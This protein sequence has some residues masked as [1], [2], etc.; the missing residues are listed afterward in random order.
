MS[1]W[2]QSEYTKPP[3]CLSVLLYVVTF[4]NGYIV[5]K[6][7]VSGFYADESAHAITGYFY[8]E[9]NKTIDEQLP[10]ETH[11]IRVMYWT[12]QPSPPIIDMQYIKKFFNI[13]GSL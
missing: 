3:I 13:K 11:D 8:E 6:M 7:I 5:D 10:F 1:E 2:I 9:P 12:L 4:R